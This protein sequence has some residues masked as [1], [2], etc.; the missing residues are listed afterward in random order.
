[1]SDFRLRMAAQVV[2]G[3][4][5]IAYPTESIW[6]LGCDPFNEEAVE[7]LLE[8]KQRP[9]GKGLILV[10]ASP[11]QFEWLLHDLSQAQQSRLTL[12]WPGPVTWLV[13]HR[14][15]VP[16]WISGDHTTVALRVSAHKR[17]RQLCR[18]CD[19]PLVSTSA[20]TAGS[21]AA[22]A[23]HQVWRYFGE[24]VDYLLPGQVGGSSRPSMIRDLLSDTIVRP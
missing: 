8:L 4:G 16:A 13:P 18:C 24:G 2:L 7:Q 19:G 5:V 1:M 15:R 22:K 17:V 11:S 20:N 21:V 10:A 3:G 9:S 12:S 23:P 14:G 6:G